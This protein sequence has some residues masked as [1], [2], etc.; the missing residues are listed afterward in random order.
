MLIVT[1]EIIA[2]VRRLLRGIEV[3]DETLMLD[4]I[5]EVGPGGHFIA[6]KETAEQCREEIWMPRLMDRDPWETWAAGGR[7]TMISRFK[8][9]ARWI[10]A[11]HTP[12]PLPA[13]AERKIAAILNAAEARETTRE[14]EEQEAHQA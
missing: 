12:P 14:E 2:F 8:E 11:T 1:D 4:L 6:T 10:L 7:E 5:D 3:S 9:R 13:G